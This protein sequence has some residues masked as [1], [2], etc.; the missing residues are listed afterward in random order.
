[1]LRRNVRVLTHEFNDSLQRAEFLAP[2]ARLDFRCG[3]NGFSGEVVFAAGKRTKLVF[4]ETV[5]AVFAELQGEYRATWPPG[6]GF[7]ESR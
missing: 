4:G 3:V 5:D 1:M 2:G 6:T 7:A